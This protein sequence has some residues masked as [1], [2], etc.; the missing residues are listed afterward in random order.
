MSDSIASQRRPRARAYG[1]ALIGV[2][3]IG[4]A[5]FWANTGAV[6]GPDG[7]A[8]ETVDSAGPAV[9]TAPPPR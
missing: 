9:M 6:G 8:V 4:A 1:L 2:V 7:R 3:V 5:Y